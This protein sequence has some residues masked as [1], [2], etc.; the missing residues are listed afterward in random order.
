MKY[1]IDRYIKRKYYR[2]M[3][4]ICI[5]YYTSFT[6]HPPQRSLITSHSLIGND[7][8]RRRFL[9]TLTYNN[10]SSIGHLACTL[11]GTK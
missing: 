7:T 11:M 6:E 3:Y 5:R 9:E 10:V 8:T 4:G 2:Q 1:D